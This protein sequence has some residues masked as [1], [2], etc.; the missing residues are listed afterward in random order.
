MP[1]FDDEQWYEYFRMKRATFEW[2]C[3]QLD[4]VLKPDDNPV[5]PEREIMSTRKRVAIALYKL[6]TVDQYKG[7]GVCFG[8]HKSSVHNC[9]YSVCLAL[10]ELLEKDFIK[11]PD[12]K[13][14]EEIAKR[15]ECK[16]NIPQIIGAIDGSHIPITPPTEG[17]A[18]F[19]N[20]K[21]YASIV[22]QAIVDDQ[23]LFRNVSCKMPGSCHDREALYHSSFY[24]N[25]DNLMPKGNKVVDGCNIPY[26]ILGDPAYPLLPW[27]LKNYDYDFHISPEKDSFNVHL[28]KGRVV[29]ENAFGRLKARWRILCRASFLNHSFMPI[30]VVACCILHNICELSKDTHQRYEARMSRWHDEGLHDT[31][32]EQPATECFNAENVYSAEDTRD[33]L[34]LYLSRNF[35]LLSS[36][37]GRIAEGRVEA[38]AQ[39]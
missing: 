10:T 14:A 22:L 1:F 35:P 19:I 33:H 12:E 2:L 4:P 13:E 7:V 20:R 25:V 36:I 30:V 17:R 3:E 18:D 5:Y 29:V 27:L 32:V 38:E 9:V 8:V 37:R 26:M 21:G 6:A 24:K 11:L 23:Y 28:N 31:N 34:M 39:G 16:S 15:F